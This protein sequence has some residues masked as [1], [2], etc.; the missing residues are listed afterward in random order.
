MEYLNFIYSN[1]FLLSPI[2]AL[3]IIFKR[4]NF[5]GLRKE[6]S[7]DFAIFYIIFLP[8][9]L[10]IIYFSQNYQ[11]FSS[12][13][14]IFLTLE[15]PKESL[16]LLLIF[17]FVFASFFS[18]I[19]KF[20]VFK[21]LDTL[22]L[23]F[24][25][26]LLLFSI[27]AKEVYLILFLLISIYFLEKKFISGFINFFSIFVLTNYFLL[28]PILEKGLIFYIILNTINAL[29]IY[30][31]VKYMQNSHLSKEFIEQSKQKLLQRKAKLLEEL[32]IID[33]DVDPDRD[34]GNSEFIDESVEDMKVEKN[35]I[36][37]KE[38]QEVLDSVNGALK[39]IDEGTY[40]IDKKTGEPI[41]K[42]RLELF[43]EADENI[44]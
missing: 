40:G 29:F 12:F 13:S 15:F 37:K 14:E 33:A 38:I 24:F 20:S 8:L 31:R 18:N 43:P 1:R 7:I 5:S 17:N 3:F 34:T 26:L 44:K 41:D 30:R 6:F 11:N 4:L 10:K 23:T 35:Y 9:Y 28:Y 39:R 36:F 32:Q 21:I 42:A 25:T 27:N 19:Y 2:I 22:V 16:F